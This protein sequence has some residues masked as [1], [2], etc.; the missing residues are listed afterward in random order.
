MSEIHNPY[1]T[2]L[3]GLVLDDPVYAFFDFC[4]EREKIRLARENDAPAPWTDDPIFQKGRFL[5]VFREDDRGSKAILRFAGSL[6]KDLSALIHAL[7]FARWC[8]RQVTLDKLSTKILS[9]PKKLRK[10]LETLEPWCNVTAYPVEP[11]HWEGAQYSRLDAATILFGENKES[12][13]DTI[14]GAQGDVI[15]AT[16]AV[17]ALFRMQNDFPIFMTIIDLAWFRPDVIDPGSHVPTGIGAVA[18]LDRLQ[19]HFGLDSHQQTC[20]R[21]IALQKEYWP[22]AKRAFQPIDIEYLSCECRKYYSYVNGTKLFEG[23][24]LF[25]PKRNLDK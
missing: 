24:N 18:F 21:M 1:A 6:E 19:K 23:K 10:K 11:V 13:T 9:N 5:N 17:N 3:D 15:K 2:A 14:T 25:H 20:D 16:N 4:R 8:N 12:L 22:E 7:F